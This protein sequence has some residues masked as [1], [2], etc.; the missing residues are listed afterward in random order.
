MVVYL[1]V[2]GG[3]AFVLNLLGQNLALIFGLYMGLI[4]ITVGL[5]RLTPLGI[6]VI[7]FYL[8]LSL[9]SYGC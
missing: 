4:G 7:A 8:G 2:Q 6:G 1:V 9:V 5:L 3:L